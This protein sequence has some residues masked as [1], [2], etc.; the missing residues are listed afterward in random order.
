LTDSDDLLRRQE[1]DIEAE[2]AGFDKAPFQPNESRVRL[3]V[4]RVT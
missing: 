4:G 1:I 3:V 2:Y